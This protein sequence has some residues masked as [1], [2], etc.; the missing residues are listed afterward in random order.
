[1]FLIRECGTPKCG[2]GVKCDGTSVVRNKSRRFVTGTAFH[3]N[4]LRGNLPEMPYP[5]TELVKA[6]AAGGSCGFSPRSSLGSRSIAVCF[7]LAMVT[8]M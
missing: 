1:M 8:S 5:L 4:C 2:T 7:G 6:H 3:G